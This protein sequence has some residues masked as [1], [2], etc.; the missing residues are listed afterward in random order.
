MIARTLIIETEIIN[1]E[2]TA[3]RIEEAKAAV[4]PIRILQGQVIVREGQVVDKEVYRQLELAGLLTNQSPVKPMAAIVLFVIVIGSIVF[5][6]F[7]TWRESSIV[8]KKSL[9]IVMVVFFLQVIIMKLI[10]LIEPEFDLFIAFLFPTALAS[11]LVKLLT[12]DRLA[13]M[14]SI[15]SAA[16]AGVMLQDGYAAI[17]QMEI[18]LYIVFGS[19]TAFI[20][21]EM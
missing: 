17:I 14:T 9:A 3:L 7:H 11:M 20:Y 21:W 19:L 16:T 13:L 1:K 10:S 18:A 15:I 4:E 2:R 12:N 5:M 8:K 6:H